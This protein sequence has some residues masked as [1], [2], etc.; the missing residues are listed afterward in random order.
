MSGTLVLHRCIQIV[1]A[2]P[3]AFNPLGKVWALAKPRQ[4]GKLLEI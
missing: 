2:E 4:R 1:T 3:F